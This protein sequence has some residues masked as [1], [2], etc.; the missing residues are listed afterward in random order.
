MNN[1]S[2][3]V[4]QNKYFTFY[5]QMTQ[6]FTSHLHYPNCESKTRKKKRERKTEGTN[7]R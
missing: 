7:S 6:S 4:I 5:P 2:K 1:E 3:E